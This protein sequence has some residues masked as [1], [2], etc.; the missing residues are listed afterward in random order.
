MVEAARDDSQPE[1][2]RRPVQFNSVHPSSNRR[3]AEENRGAVA[4]LEADLVLGRRFGRDG[5]RLLDV[6]LAALAP[7]GPDRAFEVCGV[8]HDTQ[9]PVLTYRIVRGPHLQRHLVVG[10][11]IDRLDVAPGSEIPKVDT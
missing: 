3:I 7:P 10:A 2:G 9:E 5:R 6:E 1:C 4:A 8:D 11:E